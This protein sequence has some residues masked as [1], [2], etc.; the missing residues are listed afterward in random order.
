[1]YIWLICSSL[2]NLFS[3][4]ATFCTNLKLLIINYKNWNN[5]RWNYNII[6]AYDKTLNANI[7]TILYSKDII[8]TIIK[9][10]IIEISEL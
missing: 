8:I 10:H 9:Y 2:K 5:Y 7:F 6:T 4:Y 1:M 3:N